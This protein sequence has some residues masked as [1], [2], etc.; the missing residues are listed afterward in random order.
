MGHFS[1]DC[2]KGGGGACHNC[3]GEGHMSKECTEERKI[4]C[5]NCDEFGHMSKECPKPRNSEFLDLFTVSPLT[6]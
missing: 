1:K 3:G 2:P 4:K 5:R 6:I